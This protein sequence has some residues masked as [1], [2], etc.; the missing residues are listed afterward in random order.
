MMKRRELPIPPHFDRRGVGEVWRVPYEDRAREAAQWTRQHAIA[1]AARDRIRVCLVLVDVQNTFCIPGFELYVGG[2][3]GTGAV[4]DNRRLCEFLYRNLGVITEVCPTMDTHQVIQIFHAVYLVNDREEH[5]PPYTTVSAED[6]EKGVWRFNPAVAPS[7]GIEE[8]YGQ[9]HLAHYTRRLK[10]SGKYDLT[11]WPY[12]AML[13]GIGHALVPAVEEAV[14]FHGVARVSHPDFYVKGQHPLTEHY[15]VLGPEVV[16]GPDG[17]P[18]GEKS[19]KFF[20]KLLEFDAVVIAG[21]AKSHC[22]AWTIDDLLEDVLAR[23]RRL[24]E[25]VY[26]LEDCTSPVVVPGVID[27]TDQADAAFQRFAGAGMRVVR[28][29]EPMAG[30]PGMTLV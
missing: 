16:D 10:A 9:R 6:V 21:Q 29:T 8:T 3:S 7:L 22:V 15:S 2:R 28:S 20:R 1:P 13:G 14:F 18:V 11:V 12:H 5:P 4:D 17:E 24:A 27:Y 23:D 19:G 30:W 26:L 25:K